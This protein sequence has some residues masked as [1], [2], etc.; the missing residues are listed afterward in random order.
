MSTVRMLTVAFTAVLVAA[1]STP[2][3]SSP[4]ET[5]SI[6]GPDS[7]RDED[8]PRT[9][10]DAEESDLPRDTADADGGEDIREDTMA[11]TESDGDVL[12][13]ADAAPDTV[14]DASDDPDV[15]AGQGTIGMEILRQHG[16]PIHA[17]FAAIGGGGLIAGI[18]AYVKQVRP[19]IKVI[20]VQHVDSDAMAQS[21]KAGERV[22]LDTVGVFSD[23]TAVK[24]VGAETFN[25]VQQYVDD[26]IVVDTDE[27]CAAIKDF[28]TATRTL[29]E[30]A[31]ALAV[32]G[33]KQYVAATGI[34]DETLAAVSCGANMNFDR[35]RFLSERAVLG[36]IS[37]S[38]FAVTI[39]ERPG[40]FKRFCELVGHR[41]VTE[42]NYRISDD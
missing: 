9:F 4:A 36:A 22:R 40:S 2:P 18:A 3:S 41:N 27:T 12:G 19:D 6:S 42:F 39:P 23:G 17:I 34:Q 25:L 29:L 15:I 21:V 35:L 32:A 14:E 7:G 10:E 37:E 16:D 5:G 20:G 26:I 8:V 33:L 1:C 38:M 24:Q 13:D 30:P 31:G 11:D 28:F